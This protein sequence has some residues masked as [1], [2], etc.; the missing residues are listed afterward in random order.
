MN[1]QKTL[2]KRIDAYELVK[3]ITIQPSLIRKAN[4]FIN[5]MELVYMVNYGDRYQS[6]YRNEVMGEWN[7]I[8]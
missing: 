7:I 2:E 8:R 6:E 1:T 4:I 3:K 5:A